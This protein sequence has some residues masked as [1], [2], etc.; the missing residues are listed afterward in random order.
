MDET[1]EAQPGAVRGPLARLA[2]AL[3]LL[4][5]RVLIAPL[6]LLAL[7]TPDTAQAQGIRGEAGPYLYVTGGRT[8]Y[9]TDC[10]WWA[11]CEQARGSAGKFGGGYR[12]GVFG[13][14]AWVA[15]F[16]GGRVQ[17]QQAEWLRMR[18][19][20]VSAVWFASF[21][22]SV[23]G[24]MRAGGAQ[25]KHTRTND[26]TTTSFEPTFGLALA[27]WLSP[28]AGI[29]IAWDL[30]R[31]EGRVTGTTLASAVTAGVRVRF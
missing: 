7:G 21:G 5:A 4:L 11:Y 20:A 31:A 19:G 27:V 22:P 16:G 17:Q 1:V 29:E 13:V 15:D 23:D 10:Y 9:D 30:T 12:F 2:R 28:N 26:G 18:A 6:A 8:N 25:V 14:E 24:I 3:R